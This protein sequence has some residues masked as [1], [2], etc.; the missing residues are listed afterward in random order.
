MNLCNYLLV[1]LCPISPDFATCSLALHK[2]LVSDV[3]K[4]LSTFPSLALSTLE[5]M[6]YYVSS[7]PKAQN[8][9]NGQQMTDYHTKVNTSRFKKLWSIAEKKSGG[10]S[11]FVFF[12]CEQGLE[13]LKCSVT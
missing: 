2:H 10:G 3:V 12:Y 13:N 11:R 6:F 5:P 8:F 4:R 7:A 9:D 1:L